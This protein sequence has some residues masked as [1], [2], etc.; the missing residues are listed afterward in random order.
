MKTTREFKLTE[1]DAPTRI[2]WSEISKNAVMAPEGG[3]DLAPVDGGT[4]LTV[5]NVLEGH[6]FGKLLEGFAVRQARKGAGDF[7]NSIKRAIEAEAS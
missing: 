2:R 6:G 4:Q 5:F 7:A 3:Y 1:F